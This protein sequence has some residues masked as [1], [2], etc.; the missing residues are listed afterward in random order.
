MPVD[1]TYE[2]QY[3]VWQLEEGD[4]KVA[5]FQGYA[6]W[7]RNMSLTA[8]KKCLPRAHWEKREGT[9]AQAKHY[10]IKPV[11]DCACKH[12]IRKPVRLD[13][14]WTY[15][16]DERVPRRKGQRSDLGNFVYDCKSRSGKISERELVEDYSTITARYPRFVERAK[17]VYVKPRMWES[18]NITLVGPTGTG[19]TYWA[20]D[21]YPNLYS[22]PDKK[23]SGT[24]WDGYEQ[25]DTV[26]IDEA[27]GRFA[28]KFL[29]RLLDRY[30]LM[31]PVHGGFIPF[32]SK[33][34]ILTS[35]KSPEEWYPNVNFCTWD[36]SPLRRRLTQGISRIINMPRLQRAPPLVRQDA[37]TTLGSLLLEKE[38]YENPEMDNKKTKE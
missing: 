21:N 6:V 33:R 1:W 38:L 14:P 34:I 29:I 24:Y 36:D 28:Y 7:T 26:L 8:V 20:Y 35:N 3:V 30:P 23:G 13:G 11:D 22:L 4:Q 9:H 31:V 17:R 12:C 18:N 5:H 2:P 32:S 10:C 15:G 16:D 27:D 25:Q 37:A 19:K